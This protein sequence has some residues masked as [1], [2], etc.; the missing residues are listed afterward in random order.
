MD[1]ENEQRR[2]EALKALGLLDTDPEA[3]YDAITDLVTA[4]TGSKMAAVSL[5]DADRQWFKSAVNLPVRETPR[6]IAFCHHA[7][8][9]DEIYEIPDACED[10]LFAGNPLVTSEPHIRGYAGVPLRLN[11]GEKIGTLCAI[12]DQPLVLDDVTR[13]RLRALAHTVESLI[14]E[15]SVAREQYRLA[16]VARHTNNAVII[17]D[18]SGRVTWVNPAFETISGYLFDEAVGQKP[19]DFLQCGASQPEAI[20]AMA[21]AVRTAGACEVEIVNRSKTGEEYTV[22]I[23]LMPIREDGGECTGFMAVETDI[24]ERLA[25]QERLSSSLQETQDL[26]GAIRENA[27]F[28][29]TDRQGVI[30]DVNEAYCEISGYAADELVG[31]THAV[32]NSE[33]HDADFWSSMWQTISSG[34]AWRGEI[35]NRTKSGELYWVDS[36]IAPLLDARGEIEKYISIRFDITERKQ[37]DAELRKSERDRK[38]V[39][40]RLAAVTELGGIGSWE[41]DLTK[42]APAPYWDAIT[43][44]IHEVDPEFKPDLATAINFYAPEARPIVEEAVQNGMENGEPWDLELPLITAGNN[45]I[46]VRAVGRALHENGKVVKLLGSFQDISERRKRQDELTAMSTRLEVALGAS[47]IGVW[48]YD[49]NANTQVWDMN[50]YRLFGRDDAT[51]PPA[52]EEWLTA[53]A[54]ED[55]DHLTREIERALTE[56]DRY[57]CEYKYIRPDGECRYIRAHGLFRERLDGGAIFIGVNLDVT[58]DVRRAEELENQRAEADRANEAK[59][60]FIANMSHEIRTPLNGV[61]G[62]AQLLMRTQLDETQ[63]RHVGTLQTSGQALLDLIEDILDISKIEAGMVDVDREDFDVTEMVNSVSDMVSSLA[64]GKGLDVST[65]IDPN[66]ITWV[67][68][69]KKA[70]RQVL[71]NIVGNA[72]KFTE[73]GSVS[74]AVRPFSDTQL[75]FVVNDTGPGIPADQLDRIFDRFAQVDDS[76]TRKHGGTGLGLAICRELIQLNGGELGVESEYGEGTT[77]WFRLPLSAAKPRH[78]EDEIPVIEPDR[79]ATRTGRILVVDDVPTNQIVAA[80]LV[81]NVGHAVELAGNGEEAIEALEH[82]SFDLVLM[83]IQM[84]V[85]SGDEAIRRIRAS[86][87]SYANIPI[88]ALTA[89]ASKGAEETYLALGANGY[90]SKPLDLDRVTRAIESAFRESRPRDTAA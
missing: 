7:I 56:R 38:R 65:T 44:R 13:K 47:G 24:S 54:D 52:L 79:E 60:Q 48:E 61:M 36:I 73:Q 77:F 89:D 12:H 82:D 80:A 74:I 76:K 88:F 55:R 59:S 31:L 20:A 27:I 63:T 35:C 87:K 37:A 26:M 3:E 33:T 46:W 81:R 83:D 57:Y 19:G 90:M 70:I 67:S 39:Y 58:D 2:L 14:H 42:E 5:V 68:G 25:T 10:A 16:M 69:D 17:T 34:R 30:L 66:V 28:S 21:E 15:R 18:R 6:D 8:Q 75:E 84:P 50:T 22:Y 4:V 11:S 86:G 40:D 53:V 45:R 23:E 32:V 1:Q 29:Q 62:M 43:K 64:R 9:Q 78:G 85:M 49:I 72:V 71:I 41:V 51:E